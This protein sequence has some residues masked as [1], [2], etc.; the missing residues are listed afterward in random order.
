[1]YSLTFDVVKMCSNI[2]RIVFHTSLDGA[3]FLFVK[4]FSLIG[5]NKNEKIKV[6]RL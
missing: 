2:E 5:G 6:V 1:M 4:N 3:Y